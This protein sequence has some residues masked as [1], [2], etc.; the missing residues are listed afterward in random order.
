MIDSSCGSSST[1]NNTNPAHRLLAG[2]AQEVLSQVLPYI[3]ITL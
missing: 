2:H 3:I 1:V